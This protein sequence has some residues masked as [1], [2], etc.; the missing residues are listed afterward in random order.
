VLSKLPPHQIGKHGQLQEWFYDFE[1]FDVTHRHLSHLFAFYP[2]DDI[3]IH[4]TPELAKAVERVL[5]RKGDIRLGWSGAWKINLFARLQKAMDAF[6][7]L[8]KMLVDVSIHPREEDSTITPSFEGNQAIQG[9]AA[10]VV[11]MLMQ[12]HS[13]EIALLPAL[14]KSWKEGSIRGLRGI[15]GYTIDLEWE[16]GQLKES[17]I[18]SG[19]SQK[20]RLRTKNPVK[21]LFGD[22]EIEGEVLNNGTFEFDAEEG[23]EYRI[24]PV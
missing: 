13:G 11:E 12:S 19:F 1:E 17:V 5:E 16:D 18:R 3:T 20:C 15:G 6:H 2:D 4:K 24:V 21:V 23:K 9:V 10:G 7:I 8:Q 14:P 22:Q